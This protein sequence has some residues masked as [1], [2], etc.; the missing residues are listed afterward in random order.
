M[1]KTIFNKPPLTFEDQIAKLEKRGLKIRDNDHTKKF[2]HGVSYY[3]L[4]AYFLP[5]QLIK[6]QF[7]EGV[8]FHQIQRTYEFDRDLRLLVFDC[9]E[10][11]EIAIRTQFIFEMAIWYNDSHW[12]DDQDHFTI[13][14]DKKGNDIDV[15]KKF[16]NTIERALKSD[17]PEVFINHYKNRYSFPKNPP[18]WMSFEL[19]SFGELSRLFQGLKENKDK[20]RISSFFDVHPTVF[21]SWLHSLAY[22]RNICAHHSRLWNRDLA[23]EPMKLQKP[24]GNWINPKFE[25]NKRVFYFLCVL[26]YLLNRIDSNNDLTKQLRGLFKKYSSIPI[27]F[28]G[29]P[30]NNGELL[31]WYKEP[32]WKD[33]KGCISL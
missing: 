26:K 1:S 3:R 20:K 22:V 31:E 2:L 24:I 13:F 4:S 10:R 14:K 28:I 12:Q 16:Q 11:I 25:N 6:D 15:Y 23:I 21:T 19:L 17:K 29:I 5:Y 27:Q 33:K 9:I 18:S 7:N 32:L 8:D 30:S